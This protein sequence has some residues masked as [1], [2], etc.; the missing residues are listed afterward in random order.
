[1][2]A[3]A[4][5]LPV[6][7]APPGGPGRKRP[8]VLD[9]SRA[10][11]IPLRPLTISEILDASFLIV[12]RNV[13]LMLGLPLVVT[14]AA[15]VYLLFG[16][17]MY[18]ILGNTTGQVLQVVFVVLMA[19]LGGML[20][21]QGL[22]WM[23]GILSRVSLQT[24]LGEGFAPTTTKVTL[25]SSL[26]LFWPMFGLAVL[27]YFATSLVQGVLAVLINF[28][29][30]LVLTGNL[31][32]MLVSYAVW[33]FIALAVSSAAY[34]LIG[35]T[36]PAFS[37]ESRHAP[38]WIGKPEKPTTVISSFERSFQLVGTKNLVR[39]ALVFSAAMAI[40]VA[41][42]TVITFGILLLIALYVQSLG[43][44]VT[45]VLNNPWVILAVAALSTLVAL[46]GAV[47]YLAAVQT[48]LYLDLRMRREALDL[49]MRFDAAPVPQPAPAPIQM[50]LPPP[51][52]M[53]P[54]A[55]PTGPPPPPPPPKQ[56]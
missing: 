37:L 50:M 34:G 30:V 15:A 43:L 42:I 9:A 14:G 51:G 5:R 2:T 28:V 29:S 1:M 52:S 26:H 31:V 38:G 11:L 35:L 16:L 22:V 39:V 13:R 27:Q 10:A 49:P 46:S 12:R 32:L 21:V 47:A 44:S 48:I 17:L 24:V 23:T 18:W 40:T 25:R 41:V 7:G 53:P 45:A 3:T 54:P 56:S 33:I 36:V 20:L 4:P 55:P 8:S 19:M 6:P